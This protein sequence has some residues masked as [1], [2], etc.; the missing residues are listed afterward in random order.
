MDGE[1][2][3]IQESSEEAHH[4]ESLAC[5]TQLWAEE[6]VELCG[7][8]RAQQKKEFRLPFWARL[9]RVALRCHMAKACW[10]WSRLKRVS[11]DQLKR[12]DFWDGESEDGGRR[13]DL[14]QSTHFLRNVT[15]MNGFPSD[16]LQRFPHC[17]PCWSPCK[18]WHRGRVLNAVLMADRPMGS[19]H[20][21]Y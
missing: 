2:W 14:R 7:A 8:P 3:E 12:S 6:K 15:M 16:W 4:L 17:S 1:L 21:F 11:W 9:S 18:H 20:S 19:A 10:S 13:L 5:T